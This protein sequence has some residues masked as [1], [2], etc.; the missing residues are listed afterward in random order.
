MFKQEFSSVVK[1]TKFNEKRRG[2]N[3]NGK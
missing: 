3:C 2:E 1:Q